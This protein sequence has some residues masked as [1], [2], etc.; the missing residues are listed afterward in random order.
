VFILEAVE[1]RKKSGEDKEI[2]VLVREAKEGDAEV[3]KEIIQSYNY[4]ILKEASKY[5][6]PG[7]QYEDVVQHGY[8][9]VIK[10]VNKY[11]LGRNSFHGYVIKAIKNNLKDLLKGN[12]RHYREI[13]DE[14]LLDINPHYYEFTLEDQIIAYD[15]VK[16]LY[17]VLDKLS[18]EERDMI[19]R[20]YIIEDSLKE[21]A[22]DRNVDYYKAVRLKEKVLRKLRRNLLTLNK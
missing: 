11:K 10:A 14:S 21:I 4:F 7:Y 3:L 12:V 17:E 18:E 16:K 9:S 19:E 5:R 22:C 1:K 8:L 13:P 20:F 15:N 2:E 6:I